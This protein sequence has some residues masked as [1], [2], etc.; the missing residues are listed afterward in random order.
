MPDNM[1][2][3]DLD[4]AHALKIM[5]FTGTLLV[6]MDHRHSFLSGQLSYRD[7]KLEGSLKEK[8]KS[9]NKVENFDYVIVNTDSH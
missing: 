8:L 1:V 7:C 6:I 9:R 2:T 4:P 3:S 5:I